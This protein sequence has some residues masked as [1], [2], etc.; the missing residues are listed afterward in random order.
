MMDYGPFI[1]S[2][3]LAS[4]TTIVLFL[5][6]IP[7][8]YW[9]AF[10]PKKYKIFLEALVALPLV[11]P[12]T[13]LG[14]YL[15]LALSPE[16]GFGSWLERYFDL[17]LVFTFEGLVVASVFYSLPFMIQ[18]LQSGFRSVPFSL[19][20]ASYSLGKSRWITLRKVILPNMSAAILSACIL[21]F[22]HTIG[23]F[24]VVLMVG[25]NIPGITQVV[26]ISI[27]DEVEAMNYSLANHY[28]LILLVFSFLILSFVYFFNYQQRKNIR[29]L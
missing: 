2:L 16:N 28:S 27:Y 18:P 3:K 5:I 7:L 13:V 20:E 22:A 1:L 11:L 15:L 26:S 9:L 24:G 12:P 8:A 29:V 19:V 4:V 14:F 6:G 10:N 23:E 25:G 17:R 21:T